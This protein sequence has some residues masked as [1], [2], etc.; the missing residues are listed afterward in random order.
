M[1]SDIYVLIEHLQGQ[2]SDL[3]YMM[4]AAGRPLAEAS[5]G[6]L[7]A[8]LLGQDAQELAAD[9]GADR[10]LYV[11]HPALA[12]FSPEAYLRV[13]ADLIQQGNPRAVLLGETSVG[14]DV[15]GTLSARLDLPIV[16]LCRN[17]YADGDTLK[18]VSQIYGG[19]VLAEGELPEPTALITM[20]PGD[21]KAEAGQSATAPEIVPTAPPD[22]EG[23][24]VTC[25]QFIEPE[26]GDV[27]IA[28]EPILIAVGRGIQ[29][30]MNLEIAQELAEALGG[31]LCASRPVVDQ[32]WMTTGRLV[33]KSGK[34]VKPKV[35]LAIGISGAP[36]HS[37]GIGDTELFIAVNTDEQAPIFDIAKYGAA[38]DLFDLIPALTEKIKE[39]KGG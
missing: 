8:M 19:K 31:E 2:V 12:E 21:F 7:V 13:L 17:A 5:G 16:S 29:Q 3:S 6:N 28:K 22:L 33:G 24:K 11:E 38:A 4:L 23:L 25:K 18:F 32:G 37:E 27:D 20:V 35:Y 14:A 1:T 34:T 15:A 26:A 36:E 39:A 10:V 30:E 9:L